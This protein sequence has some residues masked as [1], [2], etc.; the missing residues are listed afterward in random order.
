[1]NKNTSKLGSKKDF[2]KFNIRVVAFFKFHQ[3]DLQNILNKFVSQH[4]SK[5]IDY[6]TIEVKRA[7][8]P[9]KKV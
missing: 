8:M 9:Y 4:Y 1:M 3:N 5:F 2:K 6:E 7:T